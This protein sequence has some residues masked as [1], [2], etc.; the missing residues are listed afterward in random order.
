MN[1]YQ[2][3]Q[4]ARA[5]AA[6]ALQAAFPYLV[7]VGAERGKHDALNAAA[8]N[9][10]I[11][12]KRAFPKVKFS[13]RSERFSMGDAIRI[14]WTDGPTSAQVHEI[15]DRYAAGS[16]DAMQDMYVNSRSAWKDAFGDAKYI[17]TSRTNSPA[18]V[19]SAQ[20]TV[21]AKFGQVA[22]P[23]HFRELIW[24]TASRRTWALNK[25]PKAPAMV[26]PTAEAVA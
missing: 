19:A 8:K 26:E 20:R 13:V 6:Q 7:A 11:E 22:D 16:F 25:A 12:L 21:L 17:S 1:D 24:E 14:S 23:R 15:A 5:S 4:A 18:A 10:R 2:A 3:Q 9:I